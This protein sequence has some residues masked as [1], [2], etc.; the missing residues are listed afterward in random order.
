MTNESRSPLLRSKLY[1]S[2]QVLSVS[3][4]Y[5]VK[6]ELLVKESEGDTTDLQPLLDELRGL[7][8]PIVHETM[9]I[10]PIDGFPPHV[11]NIF[12]RT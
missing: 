5:L 3:L 1:Q 7:G 8:P 2:D 6:R 9:N 4:G 11:G 10:D 12:V